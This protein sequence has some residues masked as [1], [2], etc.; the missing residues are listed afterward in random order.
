MLWLSGLLIEKGM[1][2]A[3]A[4][5]L[6]GAPSVERPFARAT[7]V[8]SDLFLHAWKPWFTVTPLE[9]P[10]F[11]E[12]GGNGITVV[13][14]AHSV[15]QGCSE[16]FIVARPDQAL[17]RSEHRVIAEWAET[18]GYNVCWFEN[19]SGFR[20]LAGG[21]SIGRAARVTCP[22]CSFNHVQDSMAFWRGVAK[23][24]QFPGVCCACNAQL[25]QWKV[26]VDPEV[27]P[28]EGELWAELNGTLEN[29]WQAF[30]D[31][32]ARSAVLEGMPIE[33]LTVGELLERSELYDAIVTDDLHSYDDWDLFDDP[34]DD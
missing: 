6:F 12:V 7:L 1:Q 34:M 21:V 30:V 25:P 22:R 5:E 24:N 2:M 13:D 26:D 16:L 9:A 19:L 15:A 31:T 4:E 3:E 20:E 14:L 18:V 11:A 33:D 23:F 8:G 29:R 32:A 28:E 10:A 17:S 27:G